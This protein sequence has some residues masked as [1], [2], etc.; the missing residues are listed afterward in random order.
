[1]GLHYLGQQLWFTPDPLTRFAE[2]A[3]PCAAASTAIDAVLPEL[4]KHLGL[5]ETKVR[6]FLPS[7]SGPTAGRHSF[8]ADPGLQGKC[9]GK[10]PDVVWV[11]ADIDALDA[12]EVLGHELRHS[13]AYRD[14]IAGTAE[15]PAD[16]AGE[17]AAL[18]YGRAVRAALLD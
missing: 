14:Y 4:R 17:Q 2:T 6:W 7:G 3:T 10:E 9:H 8:E 5:G 11:R 18:A 13:K 15:M 12:A 1:M 16:D